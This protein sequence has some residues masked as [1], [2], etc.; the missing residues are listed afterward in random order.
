[1]KL[2]IDRTQVI[3]LAEGDVCAAEMSS[4]SSWKC[5][6]FHLSSDRN[7]PPV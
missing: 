4:E 5:T 3:Q 7:L 2:F 1:M 6:A